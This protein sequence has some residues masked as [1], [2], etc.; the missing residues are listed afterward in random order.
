M[1][2][3]NGGDRCRKNKEESMKKSGGDKSR[4]MNGG[5]KFRKKNKGEL[6]RNA[7]KCREKVK[8]DQFLKKNLVKKMV[9]EEQLRRP[10]KEEVERERERELVRGS[11]V[12]SRNDL[13]QD[14][15]ADSLRAAAI[16]Q[17]SADAAQKVDTW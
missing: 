3:R 10:M 16:L 2:K 6:K 15:I 11:V 1:R 13:V 8:K 5:D 12:R 9:E 14:L 7:G 17:L 4:K